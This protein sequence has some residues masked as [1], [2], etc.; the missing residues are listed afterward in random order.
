MPDKPRGEAG[1]AR[2]VSGLPAA[3]ESESVR[4]SRIAHDDGLA[5]EDLRRLFERH[6]A[7]V[8]TSADGPV[9]DAGLKVAMERVQKQGFAH[10]V[11]K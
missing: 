9:S 8:D 6:Q 5:P 1:G 7:A 11:Q 2:S 3:S 10:E 4:A